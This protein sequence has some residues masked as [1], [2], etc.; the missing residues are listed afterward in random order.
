MPTT[1]A[2]PDPDLGRARR[3]DPRGHTARETQL[4]TAQQARDERARDD[5]RPN[6]GCPQGHRLLRPGGCL[7]H[8]GPGSS[9]APAKRV[10]SFLDEARPLLRPGVAYDPAGALDWAQDTFIPLLR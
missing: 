3:V 7:S 4:K 2:D 6:N 8:P 9:R 1:G 5:H 10:P